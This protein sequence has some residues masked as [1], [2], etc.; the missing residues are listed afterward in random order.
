MV[1][2]ACLENEVEEREENR[3]KGD[4]RKD[5]GGENKKGEDDT[6]KVGGEVFKDRRKFIKKN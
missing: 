6:E 2:V 3:M 4:K 1:G 5:D